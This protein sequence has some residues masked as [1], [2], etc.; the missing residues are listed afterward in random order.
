MLWSLTR[1]RAI[2]NANRFADRDSAR[3]S[4]WLGRSDLM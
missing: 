4:D 2:Y 1:E 3:K